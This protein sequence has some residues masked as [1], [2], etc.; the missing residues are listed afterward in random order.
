MTHEFWIAEEVIKN[1]GTKVKVE[2]PPT[3]EIVLNFEVNENIAKELV[4]RVSTTEQ[5]TDRTTQQRTEAIR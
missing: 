4:N 1:D 3:N 5:K 2:I